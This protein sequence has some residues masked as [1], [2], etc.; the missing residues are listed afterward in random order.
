MFKTDP[1]KI[2]QNQRASNIERL[3][4]GKRRSSKPQPVPAPSPTVNVNKQQQHQRQQASSQVLKPTSPES[5]P[6][7]TR[8]LLSALNNQVTHHA[9]KR[10]VNITKSFHDSTKFQTLENRGFTDKFHAIESIVTHKPPTAAKRKQAEKTGHDP[11]VDIARSE[12][13]GFVE[14]FKMNK[15]QYAVPHMTAAASFPAANNSKRDD[16]VAADV[17]CGGGKR[18]ASVVESVVQ[19]SYVRPEFRRLSTQV[20]GGGVYRVVKVAHLSPFMLSVRLQAQLGLESDADTKTVDSI[21]LNVYKVELSAGDVVKLLDQRGEKSC[22]F[23][24][25]LSGDRLI[26]AHAKWE[27]LK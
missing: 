18:D 13:S 4:R 1:F 26:E 7:S 3:K 20:T 19:S 8:R 12:F 14:W 17:A 24:M 27:I 5:K 22:S 2:Y 11:V 9:K 21:L 23:T 15:Y 16:M 6:V 25:K 10:D